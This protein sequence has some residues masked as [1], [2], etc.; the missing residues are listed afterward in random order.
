V[1]LSVQRMEGG[2]WSN[3]AK[4][5]TNDKREPDDQARMQLIQQLLAAMLNVMMDTDLNLDTWDVNDSGFLQSIQFINDAKA[6]YCGED[7]ELI[8]AWVAELD[9]FNNGGMETPLPEGVNPSANPKTAKDVADTV[10]W[11]ILP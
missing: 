9:A 2:F 11:D 3:I 7:R 1:P 8:L 4:T 5:S 10:I 6:A